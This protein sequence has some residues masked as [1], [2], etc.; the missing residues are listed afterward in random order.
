M[1]VQCQL[2]LICYLYKKNSLVYNIQNVK[3]YYYIICYWSSTQK[4]NHIKLITVL[5]TFN[6][7][8]LFFKTRHVFKNKSIKFDKGSLNTGIT[9]YFLIWQT[10]S[11]SR[12]KFRMH[13]LMVHFQFRL[14]R[15]AII[16]FITF[17]IFCYCSYYNVFTL[18]YWFI[19]TILFLS[20]CWGFFQFHISIDS[21]Y[22]EFVSLI[23]FF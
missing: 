7:I 5:I 18:A 12:A 9:K 6:L 17:I 13:A 14:K 20:I 19:V 8:D 2:C 16:Y 15:T 10:N 11:P 23:F 3:T 22:L 21:T 4:T 1:Q